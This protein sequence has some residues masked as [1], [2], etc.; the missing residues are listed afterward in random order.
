M[1]QPSI[2]NDYGSCL[3]AAPFFVSETGLF[4]A[5]EGVGHGDEFFIP[6]PQA[7]FFT[8]YVRT[9][10]GLRGFTFRGMAMTCF[11]SG[12]SRPRRSAAYPA[13]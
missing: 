2:H 8:A 3:A 5:E 4:L 6:R 13:L 9:K 12:P 11:T 1:A 10:N 7:A